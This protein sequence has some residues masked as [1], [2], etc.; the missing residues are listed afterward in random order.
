MGNDMEF[1]KMSDQNR[2]NKDSGYETN[3]NDN[4]QIN[5]FREFL[6]FIRVNISLDLRLTLSSI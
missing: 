2:N 3:I 1:I 4:T 6:T 5:S